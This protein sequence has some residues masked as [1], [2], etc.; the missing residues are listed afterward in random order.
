MLSPT[1]KHRPGEAQAGLRGAA[2]NAAG[3]PQGPTP[4]G[5]ALR[6]WGSKQ[7]GCAS[8][9]TLLGRLQR[10]GSALVAP[11]G[12]ST[13]PRP[14]SPPSR[15]CSDHRTHLDQAVTPLLQG[16]L[17]GL[18]FRRAPRAG[19][20]DF[21]PPSRGAQH[22][23]DSRALPVCKHGGDRGE[24]VSAGRR[25]ARGLWRARWPARQALH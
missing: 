22:V 14:L 8:P 17:R 24:G 12:T 25:G 5:H 3:C 13:F 6:V 20:G 2:P 7:Q 1:G 4:G 18:G 19:T 11:G 10:S 16:V 9:A 23:P 15:S 21:T